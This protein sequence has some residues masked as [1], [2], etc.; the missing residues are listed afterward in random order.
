MSARRLY[1]PLLD[2]EGEEELNAV[3]YNDS[4]RR[5]LTINSMLYDLQTNQLIDFHHG[6]QDLEN[7]IV[8]TVFDPYIKYRTAPDDMLRAIRFASILPDFTIDTSVINA[9]KKHAHLLKTRTDG[10][11]ISNRR[12]RKEL[13]KAFKTE[14]T[15]R[16]ALTLLIETDL[17]SEIE[18]DIRYVARDRGFTQLFEQAQ[19]EAIKVA[20]RTTT[21]QTFHSPGGSTL[22]GGPGGQFTVP[23][24]EGQVG[25]SS[26]VPQSNYTSILTQRKVEFDKQRNLERKKRQVKELIQQKKLKGFLVL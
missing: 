15:T 17:W 13:R 14:V 18:N 16:K 23:T 4:F 19:L 21:A 22:S 20:A 1:S 2:L 12:I 26:G 25:S 3:A 8:R 9:M 5:D 7:K 10:G 6:I 11:E 24:D